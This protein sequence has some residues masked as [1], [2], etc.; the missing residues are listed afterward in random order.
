MLLGSWFKQLTAECI[1]RG[2]L[3]VIVDYQLCNVIKITKRNNIFINNNLIAYG[4]RCS[5][6]LIE[7]SR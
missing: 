4:N 6:Y 5:V 2:S 3:L 1:S 7:A